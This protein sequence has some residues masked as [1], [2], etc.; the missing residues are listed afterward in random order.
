MSTPS[1]ILVS[2]RFQDPSIPHA[3]DAAFAHALSGRGCD[4]R[5]VIPLESTGEPPEL[6]AGSP[7]RQLRVLTEAPGF[8]AVQDRLLDGPSET[9]LTVSIRGEMPDLVHVL[10]YGG[11]TSVNLSWVASRLGVACLI[12]MQAATTVCHRGDLRYRGIEDCDSFQDST[13]CSICTLTPVADGLTEGLSAWQ[14]LVGRGLR[15]L[16]SP[17]NPY[18]MPVDFESRQDLLVGG[19]QFA[20]RV[21]VTDETE[22]QRVGTLG[23]RK[24]VF[25][26]LPPLGSEPATIDSYLELY[27]RVIDGQVSTD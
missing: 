21:I 7:I 26:V 17:I 4:V 13:R 1:L 8:A 18:P 11:C 9:A 22:R 25:E 20:E 15:L 3:R 6:P 19:V 5:W 2:G 10:D 12:S 27:R 24:E 14:S 16:R 23:L